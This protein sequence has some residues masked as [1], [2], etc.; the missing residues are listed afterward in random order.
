[1]EGHEKQ[2]GRESTKVPN[3]CRAASQMPAT[4]QGLAGTGPGARDTK[5][6]LPLKRKEPSGLSHHHFCPGLVLTAG[7]HQELEVG[8]KPRHFTVRD[9]CVPGTSLHIDSIVVTFL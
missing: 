9:T 7:L 2:S 4:G 6:D 1:M 5:S 3:C 8:L